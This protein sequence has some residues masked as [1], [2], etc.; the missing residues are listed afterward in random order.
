MSRGR[1]RGQ[2]T[3]NAE[4]LGIGR[5]EAPSS[6]LAPPPKFP[7]RLNKPHPLLQSDKHEYW[8]T[9]R[10]ELSKYM[11]THYNLGSQ[12]SEIL[13]IHFLS[14]IAMKK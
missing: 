11:K 3:F 6:V 4:V 7:P 9:K 5:G 2:L 8:L 13:V 12:V 14:A 1:G 10:N